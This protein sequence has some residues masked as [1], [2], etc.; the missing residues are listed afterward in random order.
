MKLPRNH[1]SPETRRRANVRVRR[2]TRASFVAATGATAL[3]GAVVAK[4]HPAK[5][6]SALLP[7]TTTTT[8]TTSSPSLPSSPSTT[9]VQ[10]TPTTTTTTSPL[11]T[12]TTRPIVT[13][14]ATSR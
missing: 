7:S 6:A 3:I 13:S 5:S 8:P 1:H 10:T 9:T 2:L 4:E 11:T 14:G 12:T